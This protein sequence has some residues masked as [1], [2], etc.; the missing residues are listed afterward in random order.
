MPAWWRAGALS[1]LEAIA[2]GAF[3]AVLLVGA[4]ASRRVF[5]FP[6]GASDFHDY[7][8]AVQSVVIEDVQRFPAQRSRFV[9]ELPGLLAPHVGVLH[10]LIQASFLSTFVLMVALFSW[11]SALGGRRAGWFSVTWAS[12][13]GPLV[14]LGRTVSF[15][16]EIVAVYTVAAACLTHALVRGE[17]RWLLAS[18]VAVALVPLADVRSVVLFLALLPLAVLAGF[19]ARVP[20]AGAPRRWAERFAWACLPLVFAHLSWRVGPWAFPQGGASVQSVVAAYVADAGRAAGSVW[21]VPDG[22]LETPFSWGHHPPSRLPPTLQQLAE[23][24]RARPAI[25]ERLALLSPAV[26]ELRTML[27]SLAAAGAA[28]VL[29][30]FRRPRALFALLAVS[31]PF[32]LLLRAAAL[33]LPHPRQLAQGAGFLPVVLGVGSAALLA[34]LGYALRWAVSRRAGRTIPAHWAGRVDAAATAL[35]VA[36]VAAALA[37]RVPSALGPDAAWRDVLSA[38][39][40]PHAS[41]EAARGQAGGGPPSPCVG[42]L[43]RDLHEGHSLE[44][45]WLPPARKRPADLGRAPPQDQATIAP[46]ES[47][48]SPSR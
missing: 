35:G 4:V 9:A 19:G 17:R 3:G 30:L 27:P 6:V 34:G 40:E 22:L 24:D 11:G 46:A 36:L 15:Y 14:M 43:L 44:V 25:V 26:G 33:S 37:G 29:L 41:I 23:V 7:C 8:Q 13:F 1:S 45:P 28:A 20:G 21:P 10:S 12:A 39:S 32:A 18:G 38:E 16:P 48:A 2:A 42:L 31:A 5:G 47:A